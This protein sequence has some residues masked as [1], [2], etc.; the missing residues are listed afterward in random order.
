[1]IFGKKAGAFR[2]GKAAAIPVPFL[3]GM[4][5]RWCRQSQKNSLIPPTA[6]RAMPPSREPPSAGLASG[7]HTGNLGETPNNCHD[8]KL[9]GENFV[10]TLAAVAAGARGQNYIG[11]DR[12]DTG[13]FQHLRAGDFL[14]QQ[15]GQM[16][17]HAMSLSIFQTKGAWPGRR[18]FS[19]ARA[20]NLATHLIKI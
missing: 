16:N 15:P 6:Y 2:F 3:L 10:P 5:P 18:I 4:Q 17:F 19:A 12:G 8:N 1:L 14:A 7:T 13:F 20:A 11:S 9:I